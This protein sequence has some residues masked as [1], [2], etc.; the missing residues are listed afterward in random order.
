MMRAWR[1]IS[2]RTRVAQLIYRCGLW[3]TPCK[4]TKGICAMDSNGLRRRRKRTRSAAGATSTTTTEYIQ[5]VLCCVADSSAGGDGG[6]R[7]ALRHKIS[8]S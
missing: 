3:C 4:P 8:P 7:P 6:G 1:I 5:T 2:A